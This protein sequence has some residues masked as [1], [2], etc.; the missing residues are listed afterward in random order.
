MLSPRDGGHIYIRSGRYSADSFS[1][2][3]GNPPLF[4]VGKDN[5]TITGDGASTV[6]TIEDGATASNEGCRTIHVGGHGNTEGTSTDL[7]NNFHISNLKIDGNQQNNGGD[8]DGNTIDNLIDGHNLQIQGE[9]FVVTNLWSINSC[10]DGVEPI[11]RT[12]ASD[13]EAQTRRG[14]ISN[15]VFVDNWEQNIHPHGLAFST[16]SDNVCKG[17]VNNAN[18]NLFTETTDNKG[19]NIKNNIITESQQ[20]GAVLHS[21]V[22]DKSTASK[23][24][25]FEGN[26][27]ANN[28]GDGV[29]VDGPRSDN[30][31]VIDNTIVEN[32][33]YG[34]NCKGA[35]SIT[36]K[37]N[38]IKRNAADGV[39]A[40]NNNVNISSLTIKDNEVVG[41]NTDDVEVG[42]INVHITDDT[43][44]VDG[45]HICD[46][47]VDEGAGKYYSA[48]RTREFTAANSYADVVIERNHITGY[49]N[50]AVRE[51]IG[52]LLLDNYGNDDYVSSPPSAVTPHA[53]ME[54]Y[55]DGTNTGTG[56]R[57]KR[58]YAGG[59]WADA[60]T[61]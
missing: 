47:E 18:L 49:T 57:G 3:N 39:R 15:N 59:V 55:D 4:Q 53:G 54:Y 46:N 33:Y 32:G 35:N 13:G 52:A 7:A 28:A 29:L 30:I 61:L 27:V 43:T 23:D 14:V 19:L 16:I 12:T 25:R 60:W 48:I 24:I 26:Y 41:N 20:E 38:T 51:E 21:G 50:H 34:V 40:Q 17:E 22:S 9:N 31:D 5:V 6:L 8:G 42:G 58:V 37:D 2:F 1:T 44:D 10:G 56:N 45:L 11:S 36:V